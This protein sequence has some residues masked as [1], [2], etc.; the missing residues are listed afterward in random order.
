VDLSQ[1]A[2]AS[3]TGT[4]DGEILIGGAGADA[5]S[6]MGG[7]DVLAGF[8]GDDFLD[9]GAG[10]DLLIGGP[11]ADQVTG[12]PGSDIFQITA[13]ALGTGVDSFVDFD[14]IQDR[15]DPSQLLSD[16][17]SGD[18]ISQ[19]VQVQAGT[20]TILVDTDGG[21]DSFQAVAT[22]ASGISVGE[23]LTVVTDQDGTQVGVTAT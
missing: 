12:G 22:L 8:A 14:L 2:G 18:D 3:L 19:F 7:R 5:I 4:A 9:G 10:D 1:V 16:Y 21:V 13:D 17:E 23:V 15:V 6:G 20:N 11:G